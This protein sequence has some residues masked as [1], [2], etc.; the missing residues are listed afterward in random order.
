MNGQLYAIDNGTGKFWIL[1]AAKDGNMT[2]AK[3]FENGKRIIF[4]KDENNSK[5]KGPDSEG[6]TV[7]GNG[8]V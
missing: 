4:P 2:F 8:Y 1:D 6:I 5:A 7:D 3:G